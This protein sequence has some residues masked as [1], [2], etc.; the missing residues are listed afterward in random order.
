MFEMFRKLDYNM[1]LKLLLSIPDL[2]V[3]N[4]FLTQTEPVLTNY[5][6]PVMPV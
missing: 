3:R 6:Q 5:Q 2:T 4:L 1:G